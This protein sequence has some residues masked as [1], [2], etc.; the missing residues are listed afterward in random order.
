MIDAQALLE[1]ISILEEL[2]SDVHRIKIIMEG[3]LCLMIA[4]VLHKLSRYYKGETE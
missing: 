2:A 4:Q 1:L 3:M